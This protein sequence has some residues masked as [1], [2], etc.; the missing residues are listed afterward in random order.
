MIATIIIVSLA[1][2]WLGFETQWLSIRLPVGIQSNSTGIEVESHSL[3]LPVLSL[4]T[5][6]QPL[7][8]AMPVIHFKPSE[9]TPLDM[10]DFTGNIK[11]ICVRE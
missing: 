3:P 6:P 10:P 9:F 8:L 1:L 4:A 5:K 2:T 11:V 7:L